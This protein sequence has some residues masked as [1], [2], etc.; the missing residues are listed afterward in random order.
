MNYADSE[1]RAAIETAAKSSTSPGGAEL[2]Q[3]YD[4]DESMRR[5]RATVWILLAMLAYEGFAGAIAVVASPWIAR[6]FALSESALA[7]VFAFLALGA[8]GSLVLTRMVDRT[9]R[10]R[11]LVWSSFAIPL[12]AIGAAAATRLWLFVAFA[13]VLNAFV[14]AAAAA[15]IVILAEVL[16]I[17][18]RADGQ[19]WAGIAAAAGA[20]FCVFLMPVVVS[21]AASWRWLLV[22]AGA[23]I[24]LAPMIARIEESARWQSTASEGAGNRTR[25]YDVFAPLYRKRSITLI[26]CAMAAA[27]SGEG[28]NAYAYYHAVSTVGLSASAASTLTILSGGFGM[29]GFPLGA[30]TSE[31]FGRVPTIVVSGTL[32]STVALGYFWGPPAHF[33]SPA[34][35]LGVT[36]LVVN[37]CANSLTVAAN[38]AVTE[39]FPTALRG[40]IIGWFALMAAGGSLV[41]EATISILARDFGGIAGVTGWLSLLGVPAAI[42]FGLL[43]DETRGMSLEAAAK[44]EEFRTGV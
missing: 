6:S 42:A 17:A 29:L 38:A 13:I 18:R 34:L 14:G 41:A 24:A 35:W 26:A 30:W 9:G 37:A 22:L 25:F 4:T 40:T 7:R 20:G 28:V 15:A 11:V 1:P 21:V 19:S 27:I 2:P 33:A 8:L 23:G 36:Y 16:P 31:R 32:V 43:I 10:K 5:V 44:E 39:L 3:F 12:A